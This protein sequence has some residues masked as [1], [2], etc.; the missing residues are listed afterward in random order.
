[1]MLIANVYVEM[2]ENQKGHRK[3]WKIKFNERG[4]T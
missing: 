2:V 3:K 4:S 1:M